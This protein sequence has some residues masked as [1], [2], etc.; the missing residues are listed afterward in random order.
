MKKT[1]KVLGW[2][3]LILVIL[4]VAAWL[5]VRQIAMNRYDKSWDVHTA[6]FAIPFPLS[7]EELATLRAEKLTAGASVDDPLAGV[8]L[9]A[10]AL[11][12]A[13]ARGEHIVNT[14]A[15]CNGCHA[16]DL[17]G[18]AIVDS[19]MLAHWVAPNLTAGE[20]S[21]TRGF[22]ANDWDRAVRHAV[23]RNGRSS[24]MP[25][26]EFANLSDHE[27]SDIAAYINSRPPVNRDLGPVTFGP[28]FSALLA[29]DTDALLAYGMDHQKPH[30]AEPPAQVAGVALGAHLTQVC[31]GCHN[32]RLSGGKLVGDPDMPIVANLTPH[33]SGLKGWSEADFIKALREGKRPDGSAISKR[34][35]WQAYGKMTDTELQAVWAYLQTVPAVAKGA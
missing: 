25:A 26:I 22:T 5:V 32:M 30:Q 21:V 17:G 35:P 28:V 15:G 6:G 23:R 24:S 3:L 27:L 12:R 19:P 18:A 10:I 7:D 31:L 8:D 9:N 13:I 16:K 2:G 29:K 33:E 14:R 11:E 4:V 20:G 34:M 1:L